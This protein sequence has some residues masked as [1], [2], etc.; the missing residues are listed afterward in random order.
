[1]IGRWLLSVS[2]GLACFAS[3][4]TAQLVFD[5]SPT[6][7]VESGDLKA[8]RFV[9]SKK[10]RMEFRVTIVQREGRYYWAS[11]ENKELAYSTSG[12]HHYF[13][14]TDGAGYVKIQDAELLP[15][16]MRSPGPRFRY[17]EHLSIT[18][19]T[20]TYWGASDKFDRAGG[21]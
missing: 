16:L 18:L 21:D 12:A 10:E 2:L 15:E 4:A 11:R 1:M 7:K 19:A 14:A 9:L 8:T 20:I 13:I 17:M 3:A 5:A 6:V